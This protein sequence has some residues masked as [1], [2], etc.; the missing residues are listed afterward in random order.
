[1]LTDEY[2]YQRQMNFEVFDHAELIPLV[3]VLE[4]DSAV[5]GRYLGNDFISDTHNTCDDTM[6]LNQLCVQHPTATYYITASGDSMINEG[7]HDQ[8]VLVVDRSLRAEDGSI[9]VAALNGDF[10]VKVLRTQPSLLLE[11]RNEAYSSIAIN[12]IDEFEIFGVVTFVIHA[13][14]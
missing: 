1:M 5:L 12:D 6:D 7:I 14:R 10:T 13:T 2:Q 3:P 8:D 9:V 4:N 11:P